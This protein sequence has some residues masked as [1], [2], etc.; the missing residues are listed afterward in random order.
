MLDDGDTVPEELT[1]E[2]RESDEWLEDD[3]DA[4]G[5]DVTDVCPEGLNTPEGEW[6][7]DPE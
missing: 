7:I 1:D 6:E 2:L 3:L 4:A 5:D